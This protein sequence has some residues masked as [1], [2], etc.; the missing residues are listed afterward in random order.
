[1]QGTMMKTGEKSR[2]N[3]EIRRVKCWEVFGCEEKDCPAYKSRNL[4]CWL[5][6]G[7]H[8]RKEI[9]GTFIEKMEMCFDCKVFKNNIDTAGMAKTC[10]LV[11]KQFKEFTRM[12]KE[13]DSELES[14]GM[15]MSISLSEVFEALKKIAKGDPAVR[16]D[17]TSQIELI[18]QLKHMINLTAENIGEMV[19]QSHEIAI[20]LAEHFD[21]LHR[22]SQG[23]LQARAT[24]ESQVELL[25]SLKKVT[26][27]MIESI[28][29]EIRERQRTEASLREM[30]ALDSSLL[31]AIPHAVMGLRDRTIIFANE[32]VRNV[33]GWSA[34]ELIGDS[35]RV[36]Y[37]S[38]EDYEKLEKYLYPILAVERTHSMEFP[39]RR[40]DGEDIL[41]KLTTAVIGERLTNKGIVVVYEDITGRRA[42]EQKLIHAAEEWRITFDSMPYGV[43]LLDRDFRIIRA[44]KYLSA[45]CGISL[46]DMTGKSYDE[47]IH[48]GESG[49]GSPALRF[50]AGYLTPLEYYDKRL[51]KHFVHYVTPLPD[52]KGLT[53]NFVLSLVDISDMKEKENALIKS[54]NAFFNMLKELDT[55]HKELKGMYEGIIHSFVN[56]IDAKSPWTK[57]HSERVTHYSLSIAKELGLRGKDIDLLRIA[58]L[59]HDVGK[60]GTYDVILEK[61]GKLNDEEFA[62]IRMHPVRGEEILK[63]IKHLS[64]LLPIVR[65][66]HERLDGRGYPDGLKN[67]EIPFLSKIICIADSFDAMTA[68]R[69]YRASPSREYAISE[70][71][72]CRG[73]QFDPQ[74][75]DAFLHVLS[76]RGN[77]FGRTRNA[78][79]E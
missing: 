69:P 52:E 27:T 32:S 78:G 70:L 55:S 61:P 12:V 8:C 73:T 26:N 33:F 67:G 56:A 76:E 49:D 24:G 6:T 63:P 39:C 31:S 65:H 40:K 51:N 15:E 62:L 1:M 2:K 37:R 72:R 36:L 71:T 75:V 17:E 74:A 41:C 5:F 28:D 13:R 29:E 47:I 43:L 7:T 53:Q 10:L 66:H 42:V 20:G 11:N 50:N 30:E 68:D 4:K 54:K 58:A 57:G 46:P 25:E 48:A 14:L 45:M 22:V 19:D 18:K 60:I 64:E 9:Q 38:D 16:I 34:E 79:E 21:L 3:K 35:T 59:L 77:R 44:N 23:E